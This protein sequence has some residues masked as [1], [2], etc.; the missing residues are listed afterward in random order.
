MGP[1]QSSLNQL[2]LSA[3]GA[4]GGVA[5][6][7]K[8]GFRKPVKPKAEQPEEQPKAETSSSMGNIAKIGRN[9][10]NRGLRSYQAAALAVESGNDAI[11]QKA[12][13]KDVIARRLEQVKAAT[14]L[15]VKEDKEEG[16]SK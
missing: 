9:Y 3:I 16:G 5:Y 12:T 7:F 15:S 6:G 2:T 4:I 11:V 8:G 1:I 14:S 10:G 13:K